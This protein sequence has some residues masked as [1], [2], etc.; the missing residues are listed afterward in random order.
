MLYKG[1]PIGIKHTV[2]PMWND[3]SPLEKKTFFEEFYQAPYAWIPVRIDRL[4]GEP[5]YPFKTNLSGKSTTVDTFN[6]H[7]NSKKKNKKT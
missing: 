4:R 3:I 6:A 1:E 5:F 2:E 7:A